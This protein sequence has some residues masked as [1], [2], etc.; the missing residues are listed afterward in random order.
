[1]SGYV[2]TLTPAS[3]DPIT[4][5]VAGDATAVTFTGAP[6]GRYKAT[7][8]AVN[9]YGASDASKPSATAVTVPSPEMR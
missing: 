6:A 4:L 1:M 8:V 5:E 2:V 7:V 3:G 9:A